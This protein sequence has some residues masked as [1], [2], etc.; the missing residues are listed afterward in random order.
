MV[1]FLLKPYSDARFHCRESETFELGSISTRGR[2]AAT[3]EVRG[4][5][6]RVRVNVLLTENGALLAIT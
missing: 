4:G 5:V 2:C 1:V 3:Q 6:S